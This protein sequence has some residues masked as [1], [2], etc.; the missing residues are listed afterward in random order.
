MAEK[1]KITILKKKRDGGGQLALLADI[2]PQKNAARE[3]REAVEAQHD[4]IAKKINK[5]QDYLAKVQALQEAAH[6]VEKCKSHILQSKKVQMMVGELESLE[7][8]FQRC[9][10]Q[11]GKTCHTG[12]SH[13][14]ADASLSD[15]ERAA[16]LRE[17]G[18]HYIE[19]VLDEDSRAVFSSLLG[20]NGRDAGD[21]DKGRIVKVISLRPSACAS[22]N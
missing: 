22:S 5:N 21:V 14:S 6:E 2:A 13:L 10:V 4:R 11:L 15:E 12:A 18:T 9:A 17:I 7:E 3:A 19:G 20:G 8:E 16:S 1:V